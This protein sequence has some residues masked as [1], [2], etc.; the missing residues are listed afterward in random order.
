MKRR[1]GGVFDKLKT[2]VKAATL[3]YGVYQAGRLGYG[4]YK[5]HSKLKVDRQ[6]REFNARKDQQFNQSKVY[7]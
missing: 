3:A 5:L 1:R 7:I 4:L 2:G 6:T